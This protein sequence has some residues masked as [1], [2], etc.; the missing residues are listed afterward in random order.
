MANRITTSDPTTSQ[1]IFNAQQARGGGFIDPSYS[2]YAKSIYSS[3]TKPT[4]S[5]SN[6][7][8]QVPYSLANDYALYQYR[9]IHASS[10]SDLGNSYF[11]TGEKNDLTR[12]DG[13]YNPTAANLISYFKGSAGLEYSYADFIYCKYYGK[14]PNNYL[15][16]LR[17][18]STPVEDNIYNLSFSDNEGNENVKANGPDIARAVTWLGESTGNK[19]E[20]ILGFS[21]GFNTKELDGSV[22]NIDA[23]GGGFTNAPFYEGLGNIGKGVT[24]SL[25]GTSYA[26]VLNSKAYSGD[27]LE[28][29]YPNFVLGPVNVINK[30]TVRDAG[31]TFTQDIKLSFHYELKSLNHVNPRVALLDVISNMLTLTYNNANFFGGA[32]RLY[33][34]NGFVKVPF[35]DI[36]KLRAGDPLGYMSSIAGDVTKSF[37]SALKLNDGSAGTTVDAIKSLITKG[38]TNALGN[39]LTGL[40]E[41]FLGARSTGV[42]FPALLTGQ[43]TGNWHLTVGNPINPIAVIGNLMCTDTDV[44]FSNGL[45]IDDFPSNVK[46]TVTL[47]PARPRDKSDIENMLNGGQGRLYA[48]AENVPDVLNTRGF[49][50]ISYGSIPVGTNNG[51]R[52]NTNNNAQGE[53]YGLTAGEQ[54]I[55][56]VT[57]GAYASVSKP[58][59]LNEDK[60]ARLALMMHG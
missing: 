6:M 38:A 31:L 24:Q 58:G 10:T 57:E 54:K 18:F 36:S 14:I 25:L 23:A 7:K 9:G 53:G 4:E 42:A 41:K 47:K 45:G 35:G 13:Y 50:E 43:A 8:G 39:M 32:N 46:F 44:E 27:P 26:K 51:G 17:R 28:T 29:T 48:L 2:N 33:G 3:R 59:A 21:Y 30:M 49:N 16:T 19:M 40:S 12:P 55:R 15:I 11:D 5:T 56:S 60:I 34:S 52:R 22:N 37:S 1:E 20:D